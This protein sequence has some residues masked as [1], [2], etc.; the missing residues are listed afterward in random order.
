MNNEHVE[1]FC[2]V[3]TAWFD[4]LQISD[5]T[6]TNVFKILPVSTDWKPVLDFVKI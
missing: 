5:N 2:R 6:F 4:V 1:A 3:N